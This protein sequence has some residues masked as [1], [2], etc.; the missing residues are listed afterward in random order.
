MPKSTTTNTTPPSPHSECHRTLKPGGICAFS[1]WSSVSWIS[2]VR[3]A[4]ATLPGP[5]PFPTDLE[6]YRSWGVGD[7]HSPDWIRS[8]LTSPSSLSSPPLP[9]SVSAPTFHWQD[10]EIESVEKEIVMGSSERFVDTFSTMVPM[11]LKK[12]WSERER[13]EVGAMAVP[14]LLEWMEGEYGKG[15][16]VRMR[17]VANLVVARK[18]PEGEEEE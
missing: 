16:E 14:R 4:F 18:G 12:F 7:W 13:R 5:P 8:Y 2:I 9:P 17:W 6:M 15:K 10:V 11:I 3:S 1:T